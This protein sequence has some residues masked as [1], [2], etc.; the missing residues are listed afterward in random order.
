[1]P[2]EVAFFAVTIPTILLLAVWAGVTAFRILF[3]DEALPMDAVSRRRRLAARGESVP[4]R[5]RDIMDD[6]RA[7]QAVGSFPVLPGDASEPRPVDRPE[8]NPLFADL[9]LRRN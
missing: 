1:M 3:P 9:W 8:T 4:V 7:R 5:L 6:Q 2:I